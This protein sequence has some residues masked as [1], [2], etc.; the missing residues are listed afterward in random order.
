MDEPKVFRG[1]FF[2]GEEKILFISKKRQ[3]QL[4]RKIEEGIEK[5]GKYNTAIVEFDEYVILG[6]EM[7]VIYMNADDGKSFKPKV[8]SVSRMAPDNREVRAMIET[9]IQP[10]A[11]EVFGPGVTF[12]VSED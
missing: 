4:A 2:K 5:E 11:A 9:I 7:V 12:E 10:V 1:F 8:V 6:T 3:E